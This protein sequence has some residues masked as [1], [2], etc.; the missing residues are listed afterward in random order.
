MIRRTQRASAISRAVYLDIEYS[1]YN[2]TG[3]FFKTGIKSPAFFDANHSTPC[4]D[5]CS[6]VGSFF[7]KGQG[8]M[9]IG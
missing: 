3:K 4:K 5:F 9:A 7:V 8:Q 2:F 6:L 1:T